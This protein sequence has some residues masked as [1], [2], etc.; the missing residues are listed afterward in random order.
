[1]NCAL[2][3]ELLI[4]S[5]L[6]FRITRLLSFTALLLS[7]LFLLLLSIRFDQRFRTFCFLYGV[8]SDETFE[9]L[10]DLALEEFLI[11]LFFTLQ[12]ILRLFARDKEIVIL[13]FVLDCA[14]K[15]GYCLRA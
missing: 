11:L 8:H 2:D 9:I 4:F 12:F 14:M 10:T 15:G 3:Q 13:F 1:M 6:A 7:L 5:F